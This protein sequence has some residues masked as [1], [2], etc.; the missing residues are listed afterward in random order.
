MYSIYQAFSKGIIT[1]QD[2][3]DIFE[4][5]TK[6]QQIDDDLVETLLTPA[7]ELCLKYKDDFYEELKYE[8]FYLTKYY[9]KYGNSHIYSLNAPDIKSSSTTPTAE[10][11]EIM[12][13]GFAKI[14]YVLNDRKIYTLD[15][16]KKEGIII[17]EIVQEI[18][19]KYYS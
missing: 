1:K 14:A 9:G 2:V 6:S 12:R 10:E 16:A 5:H 11:M 4:I 3:Y 18:E 19:D 15:Q 13:Y 8:K 7:Y 17:E